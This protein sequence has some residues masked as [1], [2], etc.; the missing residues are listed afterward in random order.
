MVW[1]DRPH[2]RNYIRAPWCK[3]LALLYE[4]KGEKL[5]D[6]EMLHRKAKRFHSFLSPAPVGPS[7]QVVRPIAIRFPPPLKGLRKPA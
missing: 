7:A 2:P 4:L 1:S 3:S 6:V 5:P